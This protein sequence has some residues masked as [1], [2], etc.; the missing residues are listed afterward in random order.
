M[1]CELLD[2]AGISAIKWLLSL[3]DC[4]DEALP[5]NL[6]DGEVEKKAETVKA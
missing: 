6:V 3:F 5:G 2:A 4:L 1:T